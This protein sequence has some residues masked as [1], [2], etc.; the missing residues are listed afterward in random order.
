MLALGGDPLD[1]ELADGAVELAV[2]E[3]LELGPVLVDERSNA[4]LEHGR[5]SLGH[6]AIFADAD[7]IVECKRRPAAGGGFQ[8]ARTGATRR[9]GTSF[10]S[11]MAVPECAT[12]PLAVGD[13]LSDGGRRY[14]LER[15]EPPPNPNAFGHASVERID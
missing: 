11:T 5:R 14:R 7:A 6:P 1:D 12:E 2:D 4:L 10:I 15:V 3:R 8:W 13:E 9:P